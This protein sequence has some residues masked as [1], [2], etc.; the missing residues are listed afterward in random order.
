MSLTFKQFTFLLAVLGG[1]GIMA[2][3]A[4]AQS[5]T[6]A[7]DGTN[8]IVTPDGN[9]FDIHGGSLSGDGA[10]LFHSFEKF[11]L[12][13]EQIANF[14]SNP[15]IQNIL[16]R[17]VGGNASFID[18]LIQVTG[19][20]S[21]LFLMNPS[22]FIF[23]SNAQLNVPA[24][25]TA[26][27]ANGIQF[28]DRWFN[29]SGM[30]DHTALVGNPSGFAFTMAE[31]G[32]IINAGD[33]AVNGEQT[34]ALVAGTVGSTGELSAPEGKIVV[35]AV[36]GKSV[37]RLSIPGNVL[38]IE[39]D[40]TALGGNQPSEWNLPITA[41]PDLLTIGKIDRSDPKQ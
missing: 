15:Q 6:S 19:G 33:L 9:R 36:P 27:T 37:V 8:T 41:L 23:G 28:G 14:L 11:G 10:N 16:G 25:F 38:G 40:P 3:P 26:T 32:A 2:E 7:A 24:S 20:N 34:L 12:S 30:N 21:N 31:P 29:A 13:Q 4:P 17:V 22:G 1:I 5:I 18:G 35:T 39:I